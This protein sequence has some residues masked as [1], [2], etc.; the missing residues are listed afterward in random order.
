MKA[1]VIE[2]KKLNAEGRVSAHNFGPPPDLIIQLFETKP[3][4]WRAHLLEHKVK[5]VTHYFISIIIASEKDNEH[6]GPLDIKNLVEHLGDSLYKCDAFKIQGG[7][8][9]GMRFRNRP[10]MIILWW[11]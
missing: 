5:G 6:I 9:Y 10:P 2:L 4:I 11:E 1:D 3:S 8:E 7:D